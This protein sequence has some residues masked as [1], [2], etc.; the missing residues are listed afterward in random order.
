[1]KFFTD[2]F[3]ANP[4][5]VMI[6]TF[7]PMLFVENI[8]VVENSSDLLILVRL[9]QWI[10]RRKATGSQGFRYFG[11]NTEGKGGIR[12]FS[13][14]NCLHKKAILLSKKC[15]N[16]WGFTTINNQFLSKQPILSQTLTIFS[17]MGDFQPRFSNSL[18]KMAIF[19]PK[20]SI[21]AFFIFGKSE[22]ARKSKL[23]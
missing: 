8:K 11:Q 6:G 9:H 10:W 17:K 1:M 4:F 20:L 13:K 5:G 15:Q 12:N 23:L 18:Q 7:A 16:N 2:Y 3:L 22:N 21:F 14:R 19:Q